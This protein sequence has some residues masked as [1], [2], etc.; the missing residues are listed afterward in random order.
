MK[1]LK[2]I[3]ILPIFKLVFFIL[4]SLNLSAC[5]RTPVVPDTQ[6][7]SL[8]PLPKG[9]SIVSSDDINKYNGN[10][11][12]VV[13]RLYQLSDRAEFDAADFWSIYKHDFKIMPASI[14]NK[15]YLSPIYPSEKIDLDIDFLPDTFYL[16]AFAEFVDPDLYKSKAIIP[17]DVYQSPDVL[18]SIDNQGISLAH[19]QRLINK[20]SVKTKT[21]EDK[22]SSWLQNARDAMTGITGQI[23]GDKK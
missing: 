9:I 11:N 6:S 2:S 7:V 18:I 12:P 15:T 8:S 13:V 23:F 4:V 10:F 14:L 16:A 19:R 1:R 22:K 20:P 21:N 17:I 3:N 5:S